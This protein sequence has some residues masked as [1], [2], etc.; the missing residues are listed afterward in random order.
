MYSIYFRNEC[1][2]KWS[3]VNLHDWHVVGYHIHRVNKCTDFVIWFLIN[4]M[5]VI[6]GIWND[7]LASLLVMQ[8]LATCIQHG[9]NSLMTSFTV[10]SKTIAMCGGFVV[11]GCGAWGRGNGAWRRWDWGKYSFL[12]TKQAFNH[13]I[14]PSGCGDM[15][16]SNM[17][18]HC[19]S[20]WAFNFII[21]FYK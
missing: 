10:G 2:A 9:E 14:R 21:M 20:F 17:G 18:Y 19:N 8:I 1:G 12:A 11:G 7:F 3:T 5:E 13:V 4:K 16:H 15:P 6:K